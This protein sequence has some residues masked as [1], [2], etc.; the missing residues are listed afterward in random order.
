MIQHT[1]S[2]VSCSPERLMN[3]NKRHNARLIRKGDLDENIRSITS[4]VK[5]SEAGFKL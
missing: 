2:S 1:L 5:G 4:L 3:L